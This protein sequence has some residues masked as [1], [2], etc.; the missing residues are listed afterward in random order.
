MTHAL[1]QSIWVD[2]VAKKYGDVSVVDDVSFDVRPGEFVSLLGPSG[3]GKTTTLRMIAGFVMP[4]GGRVL[5][6]GA[7][8][9]YAPPDKRN[10]GFVFQNYALWPH[11]TV[12]ENITFGLKLRGRTSTAIR[13][14]ADE[15]LGITGLTG[16]EG[17]LPRQLSG[18]QQQRV[19]L[20]RA[21]ALD[22]AL[23]L[24][25]EPLSNLDRALRITMRRELKQ[26]QSRLNMT[27]LYVTHDQEEAL[28]MS[29]RVVIM[30]GGKI[31]RIAK[32]REIYE[33]PRSEFVADFVG[34]TNFFDGRVV[35]VADDRAVVQC[36]ASLKFAVTRED[37]ISVGQ[38]V[39]V[40][41]RP[42]RIRVKNRPEARE[43]E[44]SACIEM[45][46]YFGPTIR[47]TAKLQSGENLYIETHNTSQ[48]HVIDDQIWIEIEPKHFRL[49]HRNK[50]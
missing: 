28:S 44:L 29:D 40:L 45:I 10:V 49:L 22:P 11:M 9:T 3:C 5:V 41:L 4:S 47:Y 31:A 33:D 15:V 1:T 30:S 16:F 34:N 42:E 8:V 27:T 39:R 26:L 21:L 36:G 50:A 6:N 12:L 19:A 37:S 2:G 17:R 13:S 32:P 18:G 23:L 46:E 25:D 24:M 35:E 38:Q 14:K 7:D 48:D 20:A 43:N